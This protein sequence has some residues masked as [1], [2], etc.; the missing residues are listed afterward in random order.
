MSTSL[1]AKV[2]LLLTVVIVGIGSSAATALAGEEQSSRTAEQLY[3]D[4]TVAARGLISCDVW[5]S[6]FNH[7]YRAHATNF[8]SVDTSPDCVTGTLAHGN[9]GSYAFAQS[10]SSGTC[11]F[12]TSYVY[13]CVTGTSSCT[14]N[15][16]TAYGGGFWN[17][18]LAGP[19]RSIV[20][21][22]FTWEGGYCENF[23]AL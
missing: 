18:V 19:G 15:T 20:G 5:H 13:S 6:S 1:H 14:V 4:A 17:Q 12:R 10:Y 3:C 7:G 22:A 11:P 21:S 2:A 9:Y 23:N 16:S 8:A